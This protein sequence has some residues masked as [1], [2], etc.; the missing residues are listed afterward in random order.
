MEALSH[1]FPGS[2]ANDIDGSILKTFSGEFTLPEKPLH[3]FVLFME[4]YDSWPLLPAYN[5]LNTTKGLKSLIENGIHFKNFLPGATTTMPSI[6]VALMGLPYIGLEAQHFTT[7]AYPGAIAKNMSSLGY[8]TRFFYGG[9]LKWQQI[10]LVSSSQGFDEVFGAGHVND[11]LEKNEWGIDDQ[12]LFKFISKVVKANR[13]PSFNLVLTSTN[14]PPYDLP[15]E[16]FDV[17]VDKIGEAIDTLGFSNGS[18][19][20]NVNRM[21]HLWYSDR[22]MK[23]FV[24]TMQ[25]N[26]PSA[27]FVIT[28]DHD[29]R[30]HIHLDAPLYELA[31]VPLVLAG[32]DSLKDMASDPFQV[33]S[34]L[35]IASTLVE[36]IA[37]KGFNYS[38][39]GHSMLSASHP[40][41]T[42]GSDNLFLTGNY[43]GKQDDPGFSQ[44]FDGEL[45]TVPQDTK[46]YIEHIK[47]L[48]TVIWWR[49][50]Y[51]SQ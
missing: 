41:F 35:D 22:I 17:P 26:F 3:V 45:I 28:G 49:L 34:H 24:Q 51:G 40:P 15:L 29:S 43:I 2:A 47:A 18:R 31:S 39:F 37:P 16:K 14:H 19:R 46:T 5:V 50:L 8:K 10:G 30:A 9:S 21:G 11:Y 38:S 1:I 42:F 32:P 12:S 4:R 23:F 33:G 7:E 13:S 25:N 44:S 6:Q 20:V 27:L 48:K 36:L